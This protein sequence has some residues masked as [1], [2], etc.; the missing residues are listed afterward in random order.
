MPFRILVA[1]D[2]IGDKGYEIY[3]LPALLQEAGYEV[4]TTANGDAVYD[5]VNAWKP[6]LVVL[7]IDFGSQQVTG[8]DVL[9]SIRLNDELHMIPIIL[10]T[11]VQRETWQVIRGLELGAADYVTY[12]RD[13]REIAARVRHNLPHRPLV[14]DDYL[15]IDAAAR[16]VWRKQDGVCRRVHLQPL[17]FDLLYLLV[18]NAG[19]TMESW[20]IKDRLWDRPRSDDA[21]A[22]YIRRLRVK[23]EPDPS[24]PVYITAVRR[25]G[26][27]FDGNPIH[28]RPI[29][30]D[31]VTHASRK[32]DGCANCCCTTT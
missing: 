19:R 22:V 17:E 20:A 16:C 8:L 1:D 10:V 25:Q 30:P 5:L 9:E 11:A 7:D 28:S 14:V 2:H 32:G 12:P 26:Y 18:M 4:R 23:L 24:H 31:D 27:R 6:D 15:Q 13:N 29:C 3:G 21:L